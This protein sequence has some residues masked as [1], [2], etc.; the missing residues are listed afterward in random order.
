MTP[1]L[2]SLVRA[3]DPTSRWLT[4]GVG[5]F[6][7]GN[8]DCNCAISCSFLEKSSWFVSLFCVSGHQRVVLHGVDPLGVG[9]CPPLMFPRP[10]Q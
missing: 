1:F 10:P 2:L 8:L 4:G 3:D 6:S 9:G 7:S 5:K